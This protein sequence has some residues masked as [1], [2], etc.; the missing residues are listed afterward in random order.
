MKITRRKEKRRENEKQKRIT[1]NNKK[2]FGK[3]S[4]TYDVR[5]KSNIRNPFL[6]PLSATIQFWS[7][8]PQPWMSL[9]GI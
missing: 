8:L 9:F 6:C 1:F 3:G 7:E 2:E 5:K 4:L